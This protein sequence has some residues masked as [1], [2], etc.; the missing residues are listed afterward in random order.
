[1]DI[2]DF[3]IWHREAYIKGLRRKVE[4]YSASLLPHL[5]QGAMKSQYDAVSWQLYSLEN[6]EAVDSIEES[7]KKRLDKMREK[8]KLR[9]K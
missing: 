4:A 8:K 7:A 1:M 9:G 2:R 6:E 3:S 5:E